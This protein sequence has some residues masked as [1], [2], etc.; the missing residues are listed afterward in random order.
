MGRQ[1]VGGERKEGMDL[2]RAGGKWGGEYDQDTLYE[3]LKKINK[4]VN[5]KKK[6]TKTRY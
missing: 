6:I 3:I 4:S 2:R 1:E 5:F